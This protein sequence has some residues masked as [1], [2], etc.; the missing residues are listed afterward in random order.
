MSSHTLLLCVLLTFRFQHC[1]SGVFR[2]VAAMEDDAKT[3]IWETASLVGAEPPRTSAADLLP[4]IRR[5]LAHVGYSEPDFEKLAG[6]MGAHAAA[7]VLLLMVARRSTTPGASRGARS[8]GI[9]WQPKNWTGLARLQQ[10]YNAMVAELPSIDERAVL[11]DSRS[12]AGPSSQQGGHNESLAGSLMADP[13]AT[14]AAFLEQPIL[15]LRGTCGHNKPPESKVLDQ[16]RGALRLLSGSTQCG[17]RVGELGRKCPEL[18]DLMAGVLN[19]QLDDQAS[20]QE[21]L[22]VLTQFANERD[23]QVAS[24]STGETGEIE[25]TVNPAPAAAS[26][27]RA[28]Q[29]P[30]SPYTPKPGLLPPKKE[31]PPLPADAQQGPTPAEASW[32]PAQSKK[33]LPKKHA[34][35]LL[36]PREATLTPGEPITREQM[37]HAKIALKSSE[38]KCRWSK[39]PM[40]CCEVHP[41]RMNLT[42]VYSV[43]CGNCGED[44]DGSHIFF[45]EDD[46]IARGS[47]DNQSRKDIAMNWLTELGWSMVTNPAN[48]RFV[49]PLHEEPGLQM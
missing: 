39:K 27:Q 1:P 19:G 9:P 16:V 4:W 33:A 32:G 24:D 15:Y 13:T 21:A 31:T 47:F 36:K 38:A 40:Y 28:R 34:P 8:L 42:W 49:C 37:H 22:Q 14:P 43:P 17:M 35:P 11:S 7:E 48:R 46:L 29:L 30:E 20:A 41:N 23:L 45:N 3:A 26:A 25:R 10:G 44:V 2:T 6:K 12:S 5:A 18:R